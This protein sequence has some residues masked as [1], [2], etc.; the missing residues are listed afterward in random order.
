MKDKGQYKLPLR[1][2]AYL[3]Y[4]L[5][6]KDFYDPDFILKMEN[7]SRLATSTQM[8]ARHCFGG[9]YGYYRLNQG[10]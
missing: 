5:A 7:E 8:E 9:L 6:K 1:N 3:L 2:V 4:H 10:T